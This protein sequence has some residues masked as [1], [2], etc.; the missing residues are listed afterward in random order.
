LALHGQITN[1]FKVGKYKGATQY[2]QKLKA[3][4]SLYEAAS[5]AWCRI[6]SRLYDT[7]HRFL[8]N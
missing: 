5:S 8:E 3:A 7:P 1:L 4:F 6:K 2:R